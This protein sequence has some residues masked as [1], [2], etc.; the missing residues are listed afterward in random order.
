MIRNTRVRIVRPPPDYPH[1]QSMEGRVTSLIPLAYDPLHYNIS[2]PPTDSSTNQEMLRLELPASSLQVLDYEGDDADEEDNNDPEYDM[3]IVNTLCYCRAHRYES[4]GKCGYEFRTGNLIKELDGDIDVGMQLDEQLLR[5]GA[6]ARRAPSRNFQPRPFDFYIPIVNN[7]ILESVPNGLNVLSLDDFPRDKY[8]AN[9]FESQFL[10]SLSTREME[11]E[12]SQ[13]LYCVRKHFSTMAAHLDLAIEEKKALPRIM[14]QDVAQTEILNMDIVAIKILI[15]EFSPGVKWRLPIIVVAWSRV[16]KNDMSKLALSLSTIEKG[17][18][19]S[20]I[21]ATPIE[22]SLLAEVI[23]ALAQRLSPSC[24]EF[25]ERNIV[26]EPSV[27]KIGVI[28]P[29]SAMAHARYYDDIGEHCDLCT[30]TK[31]NL[32]RCGRCKKVHYCSRECQ[33]KGW[34]LHKQSCKLCK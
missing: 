24:T 12:S 29:I 19:M 25:M 5:I 20:Q 2:I 27:Q 4:C 13:P 7:A 16:Q 21:M 31:C 18:P 8:M 32:M 28:A 14:L 10:H 30:S 22:M 34:K 11:P 15:G 33:R 3:I 9:A 23:D 6:S 17:T 26:K 1:V